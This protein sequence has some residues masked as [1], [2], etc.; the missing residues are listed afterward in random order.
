MLYNYQCVPPLGPGWRQRA[1]CRAKGLHYVHLDIGS[2]RNS[3]V[4]S[5]ICTI[6]SFW[7]QCAGEEVAIFEATYKVVTES[8]LSSKQFD[9]AFRP[10][11][12]S[13]SS[14]EAVCI[15]HVPAV[16]SPSLACL[17]TCLEAPLL[18]VLSYPIKDVQNELNTLQA[19]GEK[20]EVLTLESVRIDDPEGGSG[21]SKEEQE[22]EKLK[23]RGRR[24][25]QSAD[26]PSGSAASDAAAAAAALNPGASMQGCI[27][28]TF[29]RQS[30][31]L[32]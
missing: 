26:A 6:I 30:H 28:S 20:I 14:H 3:H 22:L 15:V 9:E 2:L 25:L 18:D 21:N 11:L 19:P 17:P 27:L 10:I 5:T 13:L 4:S 29:L 16:L 8:E 32:G 23:Q 24:L 1:E 7:G 31:S 12:V